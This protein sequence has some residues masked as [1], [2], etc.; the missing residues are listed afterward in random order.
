MKIAEA[1]KL[2][3]LWNK[4]GFTHY[5]DSESG[6]IHSV[7]DRLCGINKMRK[8]GATTVPPGFFLGGSP[9]LMRGK[10]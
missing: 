6:M 5:K 2:L 3:R 1:R 9:I 7:S 8:A 4:Q 10:R